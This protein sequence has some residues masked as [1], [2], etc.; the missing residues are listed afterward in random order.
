MRAMMYQNIDKIIQSYPTHRWVFLTLTVKNP[1]VS[2]TRQTLKDMNAGWQRM[3]QS[4]RFKGVVDG[5][6]RTTEITRPEKKKLNG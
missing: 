3:I 2:D 4:K 5:F 1:H 6:I